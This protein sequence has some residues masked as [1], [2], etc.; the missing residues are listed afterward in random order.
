MCNDKSHKILLKY[1]F[2]ELQIKVFFRKSVS[3][4][5]EYNLMLGKLK[6]IFF[7]PVANYFKVFAQIR[8]KRWNPQVV[9][10]TGSSG[11]TTLLHLIESQLQSKAKYSHHANSAMGIPFDILELSR[12]TFMP[13][14]WFLLFVLAPLRA[15]QKPF[16]E[17]I[18]I[19]EADADRPGE[20]KF[21]AKFLR[22]D[23][24][25][26]LNVS[27]TH[28]Q[29]FEKL[30]PAN[31]KTVDE[32]IAYE[33]GHFLENTK[34]LAIIN[35]DSELITNQSQRTKAKIEKIQIEDLDKYKL[36]ESF[37][38][39]TI[40]GCGYKFK[41]ILPKEI[42]YSLKATLLLL[43]YLQVKQ[44][45][46]FSKFQMPP[47]RSTILKGIKNTT[48]IDSSYNA[49]LGSMIALINLIKSYPS[50]DKW[51][52]LGDMLEQ[53]KLEKEE[54]EKLAEEILSL[55]PEKVIL[56]GRLVS[57]YTYPK[58]KAVTQDNNKIQAFSK[59]KD[60]LDYLVNNLKGNE[61]ILFK[62]SQS[63]MLDA[64][65]EQLLQDKS[66]SNKLCRRE[67]Y[68]ATKRKQEKL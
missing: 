48:I 16:P 17:K 50:K 44:D 9:V 38:E 22:P 67:E 28:S 53:G 40:N 35:S 13:T 31:F 57:L 43:E 10:I 2:F 61:T 42:I 24:T 27:R 63:I 41:N 56:I 14:E 23:I 20:A 6:I 12:K 4:V 66:N 26:W 33:F 37:T 55:N 30:V 8:L 3:K 34:S 25:V 54:H 18:Y 39:F 62:A 49:N 68:W 15:F 64:V 1:T 58:L 32:A 45:K 65:I 7:F 36:S 21:L 51:L 11:K 5:L 46:L 19:V 29:N 59:L 60:V 52:V 47:G